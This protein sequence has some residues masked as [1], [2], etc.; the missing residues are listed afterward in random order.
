MNIYDFDKTIYDGDSGVD[1]VKFSIKKHPFLMFKHFIKLII[2]SIKYI[3]KIYNFNEYKGYI[4]GYVKDIKN[5]DS[6]TEEYVKKYKH[7]LK[8]FYKKIRKEN[9]IIISAS[10]DFYLLPLCKELNIKNVICT[11][12][13]INNKKLIG[14]NCHDYEKVERMKKEHIDITKVEEGYSDSM[15]DLPMLELA[16]KAYMVKGESLTLLKKNFKVKK[17]KLDVF[18]DRNF[19]LFIFCGGIGTLTNFIISSLTSILIDP[20]IAY[21]VGYILSLFVTYFLNAKYIFND[22]L[23]I[24]KYVKFIISYIPN[25]VILTSFVYIFVKLLNWNHILVYLLAAIIAI[26]ITYVLVKIFT[27]KERK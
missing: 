10:M 19:I 26:P 3:L 11:K 16:K 18:K 27:F 9:D 5:F 6:F 8:D 15:S 7:K 17:N 14:N 12:Y 22:K 25:F 20:V 21:I 4:F 24:I 13:D 2:P 23:N 1:F